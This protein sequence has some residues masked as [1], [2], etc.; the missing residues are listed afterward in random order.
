MDLFHFPEVYF[1]AQCL[2]GQGLKQEHRLDA[3]FHKKKHALPMLIFVLR[4]Y[5]LHMDTED[6][7][8]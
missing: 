3:P 6:E 2:T 8:M 7:N 5:I 4:T 1:H